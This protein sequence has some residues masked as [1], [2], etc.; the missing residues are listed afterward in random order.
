[1]DNL[2]KNKFQFSHTVDELLLF[3]AQLKSEL[4][5]FMLYDG[6]F[7]SG[8][9]QILCQNEHLFTN[10]I[11]LERHVCQKKL[12]MMFISSPIGNLEETGSLNLLN[13]DRR[14]SDVWCCDYSDVD[15]MKPPH[16]A[17]SFM[18]MIKAITDRFSELPYQSKKLKF[19]SLQVELIN[20]FHLRICQI[21][22]DEAKSP[23]GKTYLGALNAVNYV[24]NILDEWK[25]ST[26]WAL[27]NE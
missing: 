3:D 2:I 16:C 5:E 13:A 25:N 4:K 17:E 18:S 19:V 8:S 22:R 11:N 10:W 1:L 21:V 24:I 23:F 9:L 12:D 15:K 20:D 26:V 14:S 7:F 27:S 6:R